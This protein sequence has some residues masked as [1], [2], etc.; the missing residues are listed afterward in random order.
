MTADLLS[1]LAGGGR[2]SWPFLLRS[3]YIDGWMRKCLEKLFTKVERKTEGWLVADICV[4]V[5]P[6]ACVRVC[7]RVSVCRSVWVRTCNRMD[8]PIEAI[9]KCQR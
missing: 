6:R 5:C 2:S 9:Y 8:S 3:L 1:V 7:V 4:S